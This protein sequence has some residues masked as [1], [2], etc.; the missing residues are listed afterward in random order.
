MDQMGTLQSLCHRTEVRLLGTGTHQEQFGTVV[1]LPDDVKRPDCL[2]ESLVTFQLANRQDRV[3]SG[4][5]AVG[6]KNRLF[7]AHGPLGNSGRHDRQRTPNEPLLYT[8]LLIAGPAHGH[9]AGTLEQ[10]AV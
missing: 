1:D 7:S 10:P 3:G 4:Q 8:S 5:W 6:R 9:V 2:V